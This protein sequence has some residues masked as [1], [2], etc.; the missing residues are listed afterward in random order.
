MPLR[1]CPRKKPGS[2]F[3]IPG[4]RPAIGVNPAQF[5]LRLNIAQLGRAA[6]QEV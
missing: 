4:K 1:R 5:E 2:H 6:V 3:D